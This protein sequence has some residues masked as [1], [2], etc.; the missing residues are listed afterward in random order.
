MRGLGEEEKRLEQALQE[1][2]KDATANLTM[3]QL[4]C[5]IKH[6]CELL[7]MCL[8]YLLNSLARNYKEQTFVYI[9]GPSYEM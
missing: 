7:N 5:M 8:S 4:L 9:R 3:V 2:Q 1:K 6:F